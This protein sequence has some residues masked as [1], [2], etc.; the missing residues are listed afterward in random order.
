MGGMGDRQ[1]TTTSATVPRSLHPVAASATEVMVLRCHRRLRVHW[2][3]VAVAA[4][5]LAGCGS[6]DEPS[7]PVVRE[8]NAALIRSQYAA[9]GGVEVN[10]PA[11]DNGAASA[12][13]SVGARAD[14]AVADATDTDVT[15][16]TAGSTATRSSTAAAL[17]SGPVATA[18][19]ATDGGAGALAATG[20]AAE[21]A[22][23]NAAA[24]EAG[25]D[26]KMPDAAA[27]AIER[28]A[29]EAL[30][31]I[32]TAR[33][34]PRRCGD[35]SF[36]AVAPLRWDARAAYAA[37]LEVEWM[38]SANTFGHEWPNGEHVWH[39]LEM[40]GYRWRQ[41]DENIAAGFRTLAAAMQG[42][43]D[44]P[45]HCVALMRADITEV[46]VA[47]VP[48]TSSNAYLSYWAMVMATPVPAS[49]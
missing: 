48:G 33:A 23:E 43:I 4:L 15:M 49:R 14:G 36:P 27:G 8:G 13:A 47:V 3:C 41:A 17:A 29:G 39:R 37:L 34:Q 21:D 11:I 20:A 42:W 44:S 35:Q 12:P 26:T 16:A 18:S 40:A 5:Q 25:P 7:E 1:P 9:V 46:G 32:N 2:L 24:A 45:P 10:P 19:A 38:Q 31:A 30:A 22:T 6:T 28:F